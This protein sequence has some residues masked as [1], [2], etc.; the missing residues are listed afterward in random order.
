MLHILSN[1]GYAF[2]PAPWKAE[3]K[4]LMET[5][6]LF[7]LFNYLDGHNFRLNIEKGLPWN[8][9][10]SFILV[11]G[12]EKKGYKLLEKAQVMKQF[13]ATTL[14]SIEWRGGGTQKLLGVRQTK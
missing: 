4:S 6:I 10:A 3:S 7:L 8:E 1:K 5:A 12:M 11:N 14:Y 2:C 9:L 13:Q